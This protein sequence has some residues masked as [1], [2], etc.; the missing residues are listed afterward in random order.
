MSSNK[1]KNPLYIVTNDGKDVESADNHI[2]ALFKK[3]GLD[4][5]YKFIMEYFKALLETVNS[6]PMFLEVKK[7]IDKA[8][9]ALSKLGT[10]LSL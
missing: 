9:D 10:A 2:E 8:V 1:K 3:A 4:F 7:F 6:Y 5:I